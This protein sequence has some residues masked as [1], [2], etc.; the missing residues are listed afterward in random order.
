MFEPPLVIFSADTGTT[1]DR[2]LDLT[3]STIIVDSNDFVGVKLAAQALANDLGRV[4]GG[5]AAALIQSTHGSPV[6]LSTKTAIIIGSLESSAI[7]QALVQ[8]GHIDV[9]A[10][11]GKWECFTTKV[12]NSPPGLPGCDRALVIAGSD[13]RG[14]IYGVYTL[15][16]QIGVSP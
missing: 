5:D 7:I 1:G 10:I 15:A 11:E 14:A 6:S 12:V 3:I 16:E 4:T 8:Q 13:K 9:D 2:H